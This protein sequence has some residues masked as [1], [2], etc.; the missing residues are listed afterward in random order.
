MRN[1]SSRQQR[2]I[3][4]SGFLFAAVMLIFA[5]V[6]IMK[7]VPAYMQNAQIQNI[8]DAMVQDPELRNAR[9]S[10]IRM[11]YI[12]RAMVN[13]ITAI[14]ADEIEVEKDANGLSLSA[15]YTVKI[16]LA[17]N[18]SLLLEFNIKSPK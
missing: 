18:A 14:K 1:V 4:F 3:S 13:D 9:V 10:D 16:P 12:K 15:A 5:A 7:L 2:G 8:F 11:A 17:G 6:G